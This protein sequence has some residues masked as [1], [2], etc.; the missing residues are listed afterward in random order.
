MCVYLQVCVYTS[1]LLAWFLNFLLLI[2][3][4]ANMGLKASLQKDLKLLR[5]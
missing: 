2:L 3:T 4:F 5:F 1:T